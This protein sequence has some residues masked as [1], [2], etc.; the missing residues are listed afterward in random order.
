M[1]FPARLRALNL[2]LNHARDAAHT[3]ADTTLDELYHRRE[4]ERETLNPKRRPSRDPSRLASWIATLK[5][6]SYDAETP[7]EVGEKCARSCHQVSSLMQIECK[8]F[9]WRFLNPAQEFPI[10]IFRAK[11]V[12]ISEN[13]FETR[14]LLELIYNVYNVIVLIYYHFYINLYSLIW[15][16]VWS[17]TILSL[18]AIHK[19]HFESPAKFSY[20]YVISPR[21]GSL[22]NSTRASWGFRHRPRPTGWDRE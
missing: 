8:G 17:I 5:S 9:Y 13:F 2:T 12:G 22:L 1:T 4:F 21:K 11:P 7:R 18:N 3:R 10:K 6:V 19:L 20:R 14:K 15:R 16:F